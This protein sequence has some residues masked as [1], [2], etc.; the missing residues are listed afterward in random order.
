M[1]YLKIHI[2][3]WKNNAW[4]WQAAMMATFM[5]TV[6]QEVVEIIGVW[7]KICD[8]RWTDLSIDENR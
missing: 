5:S 8:K 4:S 1:V 2:S 3:N 7:G 6:V